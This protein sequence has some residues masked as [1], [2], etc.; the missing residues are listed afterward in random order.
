[1][2]Q[3]QTE[4]P[5]PFHDVSWHDQH[6]N[7]DAHFYLSFYPCLCLCFDLYDDACASYAPCPS[8]CPGPCAFYAS[9]PCLWTHFLIFLQ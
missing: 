8:L 9:S 7:L 2:K 4:I 6:W 1:M 3:H 5:Q